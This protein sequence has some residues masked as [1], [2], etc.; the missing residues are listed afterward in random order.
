MA[1]IT[2]AGISKG[3]VLRIALG[4]HLRKQL[5]IYLTISSCTV[6]I[7]L[8]TT[9]ESLYFWNGIEHL[10]V[11]YVHLLHRSLALFSVLVATGVCE[12]PSPQ[13]IFCTAAF[14]NV[15]TQIT[16]TYTLVLH[17]L[18]AVH[19]TTRHTPLENRVLQH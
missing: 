2:Y 16:H 3:L 7:T 19:D 11:L 18:I 4:V 6:T 13:I 1:S 5:S 10:R 14:V 15:Y 8:N 12:N 9:T 17:S